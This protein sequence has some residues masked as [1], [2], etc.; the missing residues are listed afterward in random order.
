MTHKINL[1]VALGDAIL[2][3]AFAYGG[4]VTHELFF[5]DSLVLSVLHAALPFALV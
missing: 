4:E 3:L 1:L 5:P 2:L